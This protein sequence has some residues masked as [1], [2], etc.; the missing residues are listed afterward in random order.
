MKSKKIGIILSAILLITGIGLIFF[1]LC[2]G[3]NTIISNIG[4]GVLGSG[5]V[6]FVISIGEYFV[7]KKATL[8][9]YFS[10]ALSV[11]NQ[12]GKIKY[13]AVT[14][15]TRL[16]V[17]YVIEKDKTDEFTE[18]M[19]HS[20]EKAYNNLYNYYLS[21]EKY[22]DHINFKELEEKQ[23]SQIFD[24]WAEKEI[25]KIQE[26]KKSVLIISNIDFHILENTYGKLD[27]IFGNKNRKINKNFITRKWIYNNIHEPL[28]ELVNF[29]KSESF[30]FCEENSNMMTLDIIVDRISIINSKIFKK[31]V[32]NDVCIDDYVA[33]KIIFPFFDD[34]LNKLEILRSKI[35]HTNPQEIK[36]RIIVSR[37]ELRDNKKE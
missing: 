29:F 37:M 5:L 12:L 3:K 17:R 32:N 26:V 22:Q 15:E 36:E 6:T 35:Y 16:L 27:F 31:V 30:Y 11:L 19:I 21:D 24:I 2:E 9:E 34:T 14:D 28:R 25:E 18:L 4:I 33:I 13:H 8:E 7:E 10:N 23:L 20:K 1:H